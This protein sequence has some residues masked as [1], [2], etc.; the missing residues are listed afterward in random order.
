MSATIALAQEGARPTAEKWRPKDGTY[1]SVRTDPKYDRCLDFG[2]LAVEL[3]K[4][5]IGGNEWGCKIV[6]LTDTAPSTVRLDVACTT[7]E[8]EKPYNEI[9][10]LKKIDDKKILYR[11]ATNGKFKSSGEQMSYC[12][13]EAQ[14][15]FTD[16]K[17]RK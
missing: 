12:P 1:L 17:K 6:K 2:D 15:M 5:S 10:V 16:S 3:A 9:I 11:A 7:L 14:R 13:D 8:N 4:K